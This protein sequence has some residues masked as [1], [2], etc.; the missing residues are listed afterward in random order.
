MIE[1]LKS[2]WYFRMWLLFWIPC[3]LLAFI[4]LIILGN[5]SRKNQHHEDTKIWW[6]NASMI[7]YPQFH[8]R[9]PESSGSIGAVNCA[10]DGGNS[11]DTQPCESWEGYSPGDISQCVA[12]K[13]AGCAVT[14]NFK[15]RPWQETIQC[16]VTAFSPIN[17][18][19]LLA[20][21]IEDYN[22]N[23]NVGG[24]SYASIWIA[25]TTNAHIQLSKSITTFDHKPFNLWF[26]QLVYHS[27][28]HQFGTYSVQIEMPGMGVFHYDKMNMYNPWR[29]VGDIGGFAFFVF[30]LHVAVMIIFGVC[31]T[32]NST[33][34]SQS[35][36][37]VLS[38]S[39]HDNDGAYT[40]M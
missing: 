5:I 31:L 7:D 28:V 16:N 18:S 8:F 21:E 25:P 23:A 36:T 40:K 26:R 13:T 12:V 14:N 4:C 24:N 39:I 32:N 29:A 34:L 19:L 3:G 10:F 22:T 11:L 17:A 20:W 37:T 38:G 1:D 35:T 2:S 15:D 9:L 27:T 6:E 30:L 33:Y